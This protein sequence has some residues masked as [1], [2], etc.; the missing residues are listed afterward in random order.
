MKNV[1]TC[2]TARLKGH[3]VPFPFKNH[4]LTVK[5]KCTAKRST[6]CYG[7]GVVSICEVCT[8]YASDHPMC[9]NHLLSLCQLCL[10]K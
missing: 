6:L 5:W 1:A 4:I 8:W 3:Q 2:C 9:V 7:G 10:P